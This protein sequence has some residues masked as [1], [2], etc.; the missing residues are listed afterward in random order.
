VGLTER[1]AR[2]C[3]AHPGRTFVAWG[4]VLVASIA[5]IATLMTGLTTD[6]VVTGNP[7]S[8][9]AERIYAGAFPPDPQRFVT[10]VIVVRSDQLTVDSPE[11]R[12]VVDSLEREARNSGALVSSRTYYSTG[13]RSLVSRDRHATL[14]PV[15]VVDDEHVD[16]VL[17]LLEQSSRD[18]FTATMTGNNT[19]DNDFNTLSERDLREG[20][21][22]FGI[23]AALI[24][25]LLVFGTVVAGVIPL[26]MAIVSIV[27]ALGLVALL[28]QEFELSIFIVNMLTG[29]GL[30]LG[31]DYSLFVISRY[32]EERGGGRTPDGAIAASGATASRAVLFSG[33]AFVVAMLGMLIVPTTIMRSLAAGAIL[34]G[35]VSVAAALTLLPAILGVLRDG[36]D[37]LRIPIV[38]RRSVERDNPEGRF[39][40][41][42]I[43]RVLRRPALFLAVATGL[44]LAATIPAFSLHI[45]ASG[46]STLPDDLASKQGYEALQRDFP[47]ESTAPAYVVAGDSSADVRRRLRGLQQRLAADPRFGRG[48]LRVGSGA[49]ALVVPVRGDKV[50]DAAVSAVRDLRN[51]LVPQAF[52]RTETPVHVGGETSENVD[53]FDAVTDPAPLVFAFVLGLTLI[54]LTV[55]FRSIVVALSA[56]ALNLLSVGAAYGLLV[57][58][59]LH[60]YGTDLFG[61][62]KVEAIDA[63]VP[64]FLFS[65]LFGLS[66]D[67][68][69]F[70]LSRIRERYDRTQDTR[71]AVRWGVA[72]TARIIT[73]AALIIVAVFLG[74]ARGDL[75]MFQQMGFGVAV[76]LLIDATII[77]S[78]ILPSLMAILGERNWYLPRWL[79]WIPHMEIE[80]R[81]AETRP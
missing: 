21:L 79:E 23:P 33:S 10:D 52:A 43:D 81:L 68:Q 19:V 5:A 64:L 32:R 22:K 58:V 13:D 11:F 60:G 78:V 56:I 65:V 66:M 70:L 15:F 40:G 41:A 62:E 14:I 72:S 17:E 55:A 42:I 69:V 4:I 75:V 67:Y 39:W 54:L 47:A 31:I 74:F 20:E 61:F 18:G 6:A 9:Q 7:E 51:N 77:R 73:G 12:R 50:S 46:V 45:G 27:V 1:I 59:F 35:I 29:M 80:G 76:S 48:E 16:T 25:L 8:A 57:L 3:A 63:W 36:V 34:V 53:Y 30:A 71:D 24:I 49:A 44:L 38:G 28:S 2:A 26:L 37:R